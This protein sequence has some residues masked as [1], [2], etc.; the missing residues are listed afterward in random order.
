MAGGPLSPWAASA[1]SAEPIAAIGLE[2]RHARSGRHIEPFQDLRCADRPAA[3]LV[4][5]TFAGMPEPSIQVIPA[6]KRL[7]SLVNALPLPPAST[8]IRRVDII[9]RIRSGAK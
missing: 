7:D 9:V 2:P 1:A 4:L 8:K 5:V 3:N 6:T